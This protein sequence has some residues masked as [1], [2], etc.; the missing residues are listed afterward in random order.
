MPTPLPVMPPIPLPTIEP[1]I[2]GQLK[3][4]LTRELVFYHKAIRNVTRPGQVHRVGDTIGFTAY[5][6]NWSGVTMKNVSGWIVQSAATTFG[7]VHFTIPVLTG[8]EVPLGPEIQ[9]KVV[10]DTSSVTGGD[11]IALIDATGFGDLS[12]IGFGDHGRLLDNIQPG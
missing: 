8:S 10:A 3:K 11:V 2:L 12:A 4:E 7:A 1:T 9:A 6:R 5:A